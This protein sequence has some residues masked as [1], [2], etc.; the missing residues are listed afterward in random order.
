MTTLALAAA[1]LN[2]GHPRATA[3]ELGFL[4]NDTALANDPINAGYA[5]EWLAHVKAACARHGHTSEAAYVVTKL[6]GRKV[7]VKSLVPA[8]VRRVDIEDGH[9]YLTAD[10]PD[11]LF[12]LFSWQQGKDAMGADDRTSMKLEVLSDWIDWH[13]D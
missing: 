8:I 5:A 6:P 11:G 1:L 9:V 4:G 10:T 13:R 3:R 2:M 12:P 7:W